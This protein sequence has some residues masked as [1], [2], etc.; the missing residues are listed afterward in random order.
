MKSSER[1]VADRVAKADYLLEQAMQSIDLIDRLD[2][3]EMVDEILHAVADSINE[4][5]EW[6]SKVDIAMYKSHAQQPSERILIH[7]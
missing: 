1:R 5:R 2:R 3:T 6:L 4:A 7:R